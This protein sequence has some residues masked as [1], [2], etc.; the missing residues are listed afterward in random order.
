[1]SAARLFDEAEKQLIVADIGDWMTRRYAGARLDTM[2]LYWAALTRDYLNMHYGV[3]AA[4]EAGTMMWRFN[5]VDDGVHNTHFSY[6]WDPRH[7]RS[8]A[9]CEQGRLPEMHAWVAIPSSGEII[10]LT[11]R[12]L[13]ARA[14]AEGMAWTAPEPPQFLWARISA[15]PAGTIYRADPVATLLTSML[16]ARTN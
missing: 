5:A 11:T 10:D 6:V 9:A 2:C 15:L 14:A 1:M 16:V 13:V 3:G 7:P 12:Y 4:L 8:I